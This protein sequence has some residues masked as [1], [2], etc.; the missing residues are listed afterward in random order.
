[1]TNPEH[2]QETGTM[3]EGAHAVGY[4]DSLIGHFTA[5]E[6]LR[7]GAEAVATLRAAGLITFPE[8]RELRTTEKPKPK[9]RGNY[10][11]DYKT[12][13]VKEI[14]AYRRAGMTAKKAT[15]KAK[16]AWQSYHNWQEETGIK[17][18]A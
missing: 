6:T 10:S 13:K 5:Q 1:M 12:K 3:S 15:H 18:A 7:R 16:V 17:Y 8:D 14:N 9:P 2:H 11:F 4:A